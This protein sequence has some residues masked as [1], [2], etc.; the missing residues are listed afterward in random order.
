MTVLK[1]FDNLEYSEAF[2]SNKE[3]NE[4]LEKN[5]RRFG[6]LING[7]F[8]SNKNSKLIPSFDPSNGELLAN[9]EVANSNQLDLAV[10]SAR[11][12]QNSW[13]KLGGHKR[14]K[15]LYALARLIQKHSRLISVLESLD[16]G[17]PIRE[18]RDIDI[19]LA[20]RHFYHHAGWAQLQEK[21]FSGYKAI[22]VVA[23]I[24]PWNFPLLMLR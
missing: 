2:E 19:P 20:I 8:I 16:N 18:S 14:A 22:G 10:T 4:W 9:I 24:V 17:K 1:S 12:A 13:V 21:E 5:N 3:A 11:K 23:Q 7:Q 15:V 6:Q